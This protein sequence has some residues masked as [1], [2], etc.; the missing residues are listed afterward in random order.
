MR[1]ISIFLL[2]VLITA[3]VSLPPYLKAFH[4]QAPKDIPYPGDNTSMLVFEPG[5]PELIGLVSFDGNK[6]SLSLR[7]FVNAIEFEPGVHTIE[8]GLLYRFGELN[9]QLKESST[10]EYEF[11]AGKKYRITKN[12]NSGKLFSLE[13]LPKDGKPSEITNF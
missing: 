5:H 11:E 8:A 12:G 2:S 13:L 3:C 1:K 7:N 9:I 6:S 10:I 4:Q